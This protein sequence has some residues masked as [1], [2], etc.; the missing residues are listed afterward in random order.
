MKTIGLIGGT[1]WLSTIDYY[2]IIN[3]EVNSQLGD[4]HSANLLLYSIDFDEFKTL[5]DV[6]D[7][8]K[9]TEWFAGIAK[10][11][12]TAGAKARNEQ[13]LRIAESL[14]SECLHVAGKQGID[15]NLEEVMDSLLLIS[16]ASDGQFISTLQD[17]RNHR[18]TEIETLNL[19]IAGMASEEH[20]I[21]TRLMGQLNLLRSQL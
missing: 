14:V 16:C 13:A 7:W 4:L 3:Q 20:A 12:Q 1:T 6:G 17:I 10:V 15:L 9:L 5:A 19:A 11:L 18:P 21:R 8:P 2:R